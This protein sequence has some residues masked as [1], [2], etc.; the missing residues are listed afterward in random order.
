VT[1]APYAQAVDAAA[2]VPPAV[3]AAPVVAAVA[4]VLAVRGYALASRP[5]PVA[6]AGPAVGGAGGRPAPR[7]RPLD[8]LHAAADVLGRFTGPHLVRLLGPDR[9]AATGGRLLAAGRPAGLTVDRYLGRVSA[10]VGVGVAVGLVRLAG[11]QTLAG[12]A[13][14]VGSLVLP[15]LSLR[16]A[17]GRRQRR[18]EVELP[19]FLDVLSV[20]I[21][22]GVGFRAALVRAGTTLGGVLGDEVLV[23][24][25]A[26]AVGVSRRD[27][28][29]GLR[30][31]NPAPELR[32]F[33]S[34]VLQSEELG[35]PLAATVAD[36]AGRVRAD[37]ARAARRAAAR[38]EPRMI[39]IMAVFFLPALLVL[40]VAILGVRILDDLGS[41]FPG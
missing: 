15:E 17:A 40:V 14:L 22:A 1:V 36:Q 35:T 5:D 28:L 32:A 29:E 11:G 12:A 24:T 33:V 13:I 23:T 34:A 25:Q 30:R 27:A 7:R 9:V 38:A 8:H 10:Y 6:G 4:V 21:Q 41:L 19:D 3:L 16:A 26:L 18:I 31:R 39:V 2:A 20:M 37:R